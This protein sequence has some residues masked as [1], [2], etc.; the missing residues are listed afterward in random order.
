MDKI[1]VVMLMRHGYNFIGALGG[2]LIRFRNNLEQVMAIETIKVIFLP[3]YESKIIRG[4][5]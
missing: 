3:N 2:N 5:L 4:K 1:R